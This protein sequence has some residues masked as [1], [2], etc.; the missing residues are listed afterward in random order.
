[1]P[2]DYADKLEK[3]KAKLQEKGM[4]MRYVHSE[5]DT[6][7]LPEAGAGYVENLTF[8]DFYG[9]RTSPTKEEIEKGIFAGTDDV[10][11]MAGDIE[12]ST[13]DHLLFNGKKWDIL[14]IR[15]VQPTTVAILHR[16]SIKESGN[17]DAI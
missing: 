5:V 11:L 1:M 16:I 7:K 2:K 3:T 15:T 13:T 8:I 12:V 10:V 6:S 17:E 14:N 4:L 9:I